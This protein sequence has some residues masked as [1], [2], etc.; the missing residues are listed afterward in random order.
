MSHKQLSAK[1]RIVLEKLFSSKLRQKEIA[2]IL[3]RP[4]STISKELAR[5]K[6]GNGKY[7]VKT[8]KK[9]L[10]KRRTKANQKFK[11]LCSKSSLKQ[12]VIRKL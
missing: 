3:G 11:K 5:N 12:Y 1:E 7:S 8:A 2:R 6:D 4:S 9:K 10:K